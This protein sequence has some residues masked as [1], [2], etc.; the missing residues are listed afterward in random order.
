PPL[1]QVELGENKVIAVGEE[2]RIAV[3]ASEAITDYTWTPL[4]PGDDG[5]GSHLFSFR[6]QASEWIRLEARTAAGCVATDSLRLLVLKDRPIYAPNVFSPNGDGINDFF[7]LRGPAGQE[8]VV[9]ELLVFDRWGATVFAG[10]QLPLNSDATGWDGNLEGE[11]AGT[12]AYVYR[13]R[14]RY[15]DGE[16]QEI[17]GSFLLLR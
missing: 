4:M 11:S 14:V 6:P 8:I 5:F 2:A 15:P 9:E 10:T 17:A 7:M 12:G 16:E 1:F 3:V 13:A